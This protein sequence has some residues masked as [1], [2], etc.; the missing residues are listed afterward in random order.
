MEPGDVCASC[1]ETRFNFRRNVSCFSRNEVTFGLIHRLKYNGEG[2]LAR[3]LGK[4]LAKIV[5]REGLNEGC[6]GFVPVPLH[7]VRE[8]E[9]GYN[10]A[11]LIA[12]ELGKSFKLPVCRLLRRVIATPKQ[13]VLT[14][15]QRKKNLK[16]AF[17]VQ[18]DK[19]VS[20][21]RWILVDDVF[22]TGSTLDEC[23]R[24]LRL[25]GAEDVNAIT[26]CH[27]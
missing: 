26:V 15:A 21:K 1:K 25:A 22:T 10:Q 20:G 12:K 9:R 23:A 13:T 7:P 6:A 24:M 17:V 27:A 14:R 4:A 16:N 2:W 8:R 3:P 11:D 19:K 18:N 5:E